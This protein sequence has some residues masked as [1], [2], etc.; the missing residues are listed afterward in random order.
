MSLTEGEKTAIE[1]YRTS[2]YAVAK[3]I[4]RLLAENEELRI[5]SLNRTMKDNLDMA[6]MSNQLIALQAKLDAMKKAWEPFVRFL[7]IVSVKQVDEPDELP[8]LGMGRSIHDVPTMGEVR[9]LDKLIG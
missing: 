2:Q 6:S 8:M 7:N 5:K 4:D 1:L 3:I 9:T